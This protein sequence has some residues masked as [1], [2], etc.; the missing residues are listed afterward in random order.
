MESSSTSGFHFASHSY[1]Q[2]ESYNASES[3]GQGKT[4]KVRADGVLNADIFK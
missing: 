4:P 3:I 1:L 2:N